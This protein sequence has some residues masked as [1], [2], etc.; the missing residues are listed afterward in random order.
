MVRQELRALTSNRTFVVL[1]IGAGLHI[2]FR[3]LQVVVFD[4]AATKASLAFIMVLREFTAFHVGPRLFMDFLRGQ[5]PIVF[6]MSIIAGAGM[7]CDD[8]RNNL[9][10][11][12]FS[13]PLT[14]RGYVLGR[15]TALVLVGLALTAAPGVLLVVV[16]NLLA[17]GW[18]TL[19]STYWW[20]LSIVLF[21]CVIVLPCVFGVLASS[22]LFSSRR[23]AS[24]AVFMV[25][26]ANLMCG[27]ILPELLRR[28]NLHIVALPLA[29]NCLGEQL[30]PT[31][32]AAITLPWGWSALYVGMVCAGALAIICW[33]VRRAEVAA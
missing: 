33:R 15:V 31:R 3:F 32:A 18:E 29:I 8:F 19:S 1:A 7:I 22:A 16:H 13:K 9:M 30:F 23:Y 28:P 25:L 2:A 5:G 24:I 20:P 12:Y 17:P 4:I 21:S 10:E 11:V 26:F 6:L 27:S 14:W